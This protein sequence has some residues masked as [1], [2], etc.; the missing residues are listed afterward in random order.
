MVMKLISDTVAHTAQKSKRRAYLLKRKAKTTGFFDTGRKD[1]KDKGKYIVYQ[2]VIIL[3]KKRIVLG[4]VVYIILTY[5]QYLYSKRK[6]S[7]VLVRVCDEDFGFDGNIHMYVCMLQN[8]S[9]LM[10]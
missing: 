6:I 1:D 9:I 10:Q 2:H 4:H 5:I 3:Q 7:I 8:N